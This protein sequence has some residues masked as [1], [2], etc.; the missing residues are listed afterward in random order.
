MMEFEEAW[1]VARA[2]ADQ[3]GRSGGLTGAVIKHMEASDLR[4]IAMRLAIMVS[5]HTKARGD[6]AE[7]EQLYR[8]V[9]Q[10]EWGDE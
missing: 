6:E 10:E 2:M 5:L 4:R 9:S 8:V 3:V 1:S 7:Y